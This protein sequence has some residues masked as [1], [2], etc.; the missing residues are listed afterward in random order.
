[1]SFSYQPDP[2]RRRKGARQVPLP[3][4][5]DEIAPAGS[6]TR[7]RFDATK[8]RGI[9]DHSPE[10]IVA[11]CFWMAMIGL[12]VFTAVASKVALEFVGLTMV[13]Y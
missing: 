6:P 12:L 10:R 13:G 1:M 2:A 11:G 8:V 9:K 3:L 5:A 7:R 4:P